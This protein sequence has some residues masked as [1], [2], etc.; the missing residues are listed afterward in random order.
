MT[1]QNAASRWEI[2]YDDA[3]S[4][5]GLLHR[6][7][8]D[9]E[10]VTTIVF[11]SPEPHR[12][13][14]T[15]ELEGRRWIRSHYTE[16][17]SDPVTLEAIELIEEEDAI[18]TH[19]EF[20]LL[21]DAIANAASDDEHTVSYHV[22]APNDRRGIAQDASMWSPRDGVWEIETNGE[23]AS[24]HRVVDGEIV[25]SDWLGVRSRPLPAQQA[26]EQLRSI[27]DDDV[28]AALLAAES[29]S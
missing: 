10:L 25:S 20:L 5:I 1:N 17:G 7:W 9:G 2:Y 27:V 19:M 15:I 12:I 14:S 29:G 23:L 26:A 28:L 13:T 8:N 4:P 16:D 22:V 24:S 6:R 11:A 21:G 3:D 18:L